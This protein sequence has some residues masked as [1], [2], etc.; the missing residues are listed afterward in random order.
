MGS[1]WGYPGMRLLAWLLD[2]LVGWWEEWQ[3]HRETPK[4]PPDVGACPDPGAGRAGQLA[5]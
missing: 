3:A 5:G 1:A 4:L 2:H